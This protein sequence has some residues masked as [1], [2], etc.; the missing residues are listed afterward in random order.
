MH[1]VGVVFVLFTYVEFF[2]GTADFTTPALHQLNTPAS[3]PYVQFYHK[4]IHTNTHVQCE[5]AKRVSVD[6]MYETA[7]VCVCVCSGN[8]DEWSSKLVLYSGLYFVK[9]GMDA[10]WKFVLYVC[11]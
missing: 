11:V 8:V 7:C 5:C 3:R 10:V 4:Y 9:C 6:V 1:G 2:L